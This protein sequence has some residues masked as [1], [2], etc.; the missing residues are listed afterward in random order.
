MTAT[1]SVYLDRAARFRELL[2]NKPSPGD[3]L[4]SQD[5]QPVKVNV[6]TKGT[7]E[8]VMFINAIV[9]DEGTGWFLSEGSVG[10][11]CLIMPSSQETL[12][13]SSDMLSDLRAKALRVVRHNQR[14][15]ALIC[16][17]LM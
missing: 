6:Q 10:L 1:K 8:Y 13:D 11:K 12:L 4:T 15:T 7:G 17:V 9:D 16:E 14:G 2:D 3:T 5:S